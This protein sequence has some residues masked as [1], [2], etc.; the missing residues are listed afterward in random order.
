MGKIFFI[1]LGVL[2]FLGLLFLL[3]A[4]QFDRPYPDYFRYLYIDN[5]PNQILGIL[6]T[7][8]L[9]FFSL[10]GYKHKKHNNR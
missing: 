2:S 10:V 3:F 6:G 7:L 9:G 5:P 8:V 1:I 4:L